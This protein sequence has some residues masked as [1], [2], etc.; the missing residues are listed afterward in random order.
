[1]EYIKNSKYFA[2]V[3][4]SLEKIAALELEELGATD[5]QTTYRGVSFA[6][7]QSALYRILYQTRVCTRILAPL[8]S[9]Q[10]HNEK[11][12]YKTAL[13]FYWEDIFSLEQSFGIT[14]NVANSKISNSM[15][16]G[17]TLKDA[18]CDK[19]RAKHDARPDFDIKNPDVRFSLHINDNWVNISLDLGVEPLHKRGYRLVGMEA[20]LQETL[21]AAI[22]RVSRWQGDEQFCDPFCGSGTLLEEAMMHY[23][24]I[25]A[26]FLRKKWG[27]NSLP[28]FNENLWILTLREANQQIRELP[29]D[30]ILGSDIMSRNVS[31]S[32]K[33]LN[34]FHQGANVK[35]NTAD[36]RNLP[37]MENR[38]IVC[39]PPF[40]QRLRKED[41]DSLLQDL[42]DFFKQKCKSSRA[43]VLVGGKEFS[44][45]LRLRTKMN[46]LIKNGDIDSRLL[47]ID[48]Y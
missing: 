38:V 26:G 16:A 15:F 25:P 39:N 11:Y 35:I 30:L 43:Y 47:R 20:T 44:G 41:I 22:V 33:N 37:E 36:F 45:A 40:G 5:I 3:A 23:C 17:Q 9:Y 29:E 12:L 48:L 13:E 27:I 6:A 32:R 2:Q 31:I 8:I 4:G 7:T 42:G 1:M 21:A 19:F 34:V 14:S 18:I 24:H 28:D 10:A 46:K